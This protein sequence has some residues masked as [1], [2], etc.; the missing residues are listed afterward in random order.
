MMNA[1]VS[2]RAQDA[3]AQDRRR[4]HAGENARAQ[5]RRRGHAGENARAQDARAQD[6]LLFSWNKV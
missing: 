3:R 4:G 6:R 5:D 2:A 1:G